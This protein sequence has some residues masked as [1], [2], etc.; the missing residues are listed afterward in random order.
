MKVG[1]RFYFEQPQ[2]AARLG[3]GATHLAIGTGDG[4]K[5]F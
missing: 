1:R 2:K 4:G 3:R 5:A